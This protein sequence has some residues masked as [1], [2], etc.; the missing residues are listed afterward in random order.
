MGLQL[1]L[2]I[3][4]NRYVSHPRYATLVAQ[5]VHRILDLY[6]GALG[7]SDIIDEQFLKLYRQVKEEVGFQREAMKVMGSLDGI[8][9]ASLLN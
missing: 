1:I 6:G 4:Y 5:V 9:A 2:S 3:T 7:S 8:I